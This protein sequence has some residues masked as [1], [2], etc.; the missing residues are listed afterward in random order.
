MK[1]VFTVIVALLLA[2][3]NTLDNSVYNPMYFG[4]NNMTIDQAKSIVINKVR[5]ID[6]S[7]L[8]LFNVVSI[9]DSLGIYN[10]NINHMA[11]PLNACQNDARSEIYAKLK[12][13]SDKRDDD[14]RERA[15]NIASAKEEARMASEKAREEARILNER[16]REEERVKNEKKIEQDRIESEKKVEAARVENEKIKTQL[17]SGDRKPS[18]I[19]EAIILYD[20][21]EGYSLAS[22]P[23]I[24]PDNAIYTING[25]IE[26]IVQED[27]FIAVADTKAY[28]ESSL[29]KTY[30]EVKIPA[31]I[32]EDFLK[33]A[34][35]NGY[36]GIV[37]KYNEN[38][39]IQMVLG[40]VVD[41]P[42]FEALYFT[43]R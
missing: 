28:S 11:Y 43:T 5:D 27:K 37:G 26:L 8:A 39:K 12:A 2:G 6:P 15:R 42:S 24:K 17:K 38:A 40:K 13:I 29:N 34:R 35:V 18:N 3:C 21:E 33:K 23:K 30:F 32:K 1:K 10:N 7:N 19:H 22:A 14:I 9:C 25:R 41:I 16:K 20:A 31:A 4:P 36:F